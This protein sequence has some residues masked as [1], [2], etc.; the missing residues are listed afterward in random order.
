MTQLLEELRESRKSPMVLK[1][2]LIS[3]RSSRPEVLVFFFEGQ[4]DVAVYEEWLSRTPTNPVY[5]AIPGKGK[6]QILALRSLLEG[7]ALISRVY[8]F[9]DAD[10]DDDAT[11]DRVFVLDAYSIE[12]CLCNEVALESILNDE[13]RCAGYPAVRD[14]VLAAFRAAL[15]DFRTHTSE[16]HQKLFICRREGFRVE[17]KPQCVRDFLEIRISSMSPKVAVVSSLVAANITLPDER[18]QELRD[19]FR[20][21]PD[22]R[23]VRGKYQMQ[24]FR[25]WLKLL[26]EDRVRTAPVLFAPDMP[27]CPGSP[28][29]VT[30]R[31][32]ASRT[33]LPSGLSD[34]VAAAVSSVSHI[35]GV[36]DVRASEAAALG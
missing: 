4:E 28:H 5:E 34:F 31:R 25:E 7:D 9:V 18:I 14:S 12:N 3:V 36:N 21:L 23:S 8:F 24:A 2:K 22:R 29:Q 35:Q 20:T 19:S 32:L 17:S 15:A 16:L 33:P 6:E 10:F 1:G 30:A 13:F 11:D 27:K 26:A